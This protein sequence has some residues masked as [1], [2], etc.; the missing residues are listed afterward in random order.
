MSRQRLTGRDYKHKRR[1]SFGLD[2]AQL[3]VFGI[4]LAAGLCVAG[5]IY[6][7]DHHAADTPPEAT[8]PTPRKG[9]PGDGGAAGERE[10]QMEA[11]TRGNQE[12]RQTYALNSDIA[13]RVKSY[14]LA[15][16][17]QLSAPP[18]VNFANRS[19]VA[20]ASTEMG[21]C[22]VFCGRAISFSGEVRTRGVSI[23]RYSACIFEITDSKII[24]RA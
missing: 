15:A 21:H 24:L 23:G 17:L 9:S 11:L 6:I 22:A 14:E 12:F 2:L 5:L 1:T 8:R 3:S 18:L 7:A 19:P 13:A 20:W 10:R 16:R 4:G